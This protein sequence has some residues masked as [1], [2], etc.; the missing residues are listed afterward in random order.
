MITHRRRMH[1]HLELT[2]IMFFMSGKF[3]LNGPMYNH[4]MILAS[5]VSLSF[6]AVMLMTSSHFRASKHCIEPSL[7]LI[8]RQIFTGT[9][10]VHRLCWC[11]VV[12]YSTVAVVQLQTNKSSDVSAFVCVCEIKCLYELSSACTQPTGVDVDFSYQRQHTHELPPW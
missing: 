4:H 10:A 9:E 12:I 2:Q 11:S 5:R 7:F 3:S 1:S 6:G 8:V